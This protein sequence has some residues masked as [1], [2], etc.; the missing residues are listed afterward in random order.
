MRAIAAN[1]EIFAMPV[2]CCQEVVLDG[3]DRIFHPVYGKKPTG[4]CPDQA[5]AST[6]LNFRPS[7]A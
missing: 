7:A 4:G 3:E 2:D 1:D 6:R 5:S